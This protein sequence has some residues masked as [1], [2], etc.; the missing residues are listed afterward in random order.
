MR[1]VAEKVACG[2]ISV[3]GLLSQRIGCRKK[4]ALYIDYYDRIVLA[5]RAEVAR[6][7]T[8][9]CPTRFSGC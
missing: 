5:V 8:A 7:V 2:L 4:K 6:A 3:T 1:K 9:G